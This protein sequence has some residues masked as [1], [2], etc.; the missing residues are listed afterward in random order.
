MG[1]RA[2][3]TSRRTDLAADSPLEEEGFELPVPSES[4]PA[5]S[6][7]NRDCEIRGDAGGV[8]GTRNRFSHLC[9]KLE[10]VL[11]E[12]LRAQAP[13]TEVARHQRAESLARSTNY[14]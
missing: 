14:Q 2:T 5:P 9:R 6:G 4:T 3:G 7:T 1:F 10:P 11:L 12:G 13:S 8:A